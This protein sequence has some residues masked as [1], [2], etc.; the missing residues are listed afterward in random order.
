MKEFF[1]KH[2]EFKR[3]AIGGLCFFGAA[4]LLIYAMN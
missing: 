4:F 2:P 1:T 3:A